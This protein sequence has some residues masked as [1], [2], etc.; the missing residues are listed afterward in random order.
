MRVSL[1]L[2]G[3]TIKDSRFLIAEDDTQGSGLCRD[4]LVRL[5]FLSHRGAR[6]PVALLS[7][8]LQ[9]V[10]GH[11][12]PREPLQDCLCRNPRSG[13]GFMHFKQS[14]GKGNDVEAQLRFLGCHDMRRLS[15]T[16]LPPASDVRLAKKPGFF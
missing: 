2:Q 8:F 1:T 7:I 15:L 4:D 14:R 9:D 3:R 16:S 11:S 10:D 12:C 5:R 6:R 13:G